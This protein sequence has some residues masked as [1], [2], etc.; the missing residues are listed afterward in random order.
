MPSFAG[1]WER[2]CLL[3]TKNAGGMCPFKIILASVQKKSPGV[4]SIKKSKQSL[5]QVMLACVF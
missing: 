4:I 5:W 1:E 3:G 2:K